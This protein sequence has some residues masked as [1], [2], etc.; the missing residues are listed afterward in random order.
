VTRWGAAVRADALD[1]LTAGGWA[2]LEAH[3]VRTIIDLRNDG[4]LTPD[5][6]PR[7][8]R[9]ITVH[10]PLDG[11]EDR[12]FWDR[13]GSGPQ[14]G[15]PLYYGAHLDRFPQRSAAVV[16]AI[17]HA[18]P[19]G[20]LFHCGIGRDRT[21]LVTMLLLS[22]LGVP[23]QD[24]AA[25]YALSAERLPPLFARRGEEDHGPV[26]EEFFAREGTSARAAIISTLAALD[27]AAFARAGGLTDGDLRA[28]RARLL[29]PAGPEAADAA[30]V[31]GRR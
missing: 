28:L 17:A 18:A 20:V 24:I 14:F 26:L 13:W 30:V 10:L 15:T 27:G 3:G 31:A 7:P 12:E 25:D 1:H 9:L 22:L 23:P 4:E 11:I 5:A 29:A 2:A 21:G 6:E 19:G 8:G 16:A